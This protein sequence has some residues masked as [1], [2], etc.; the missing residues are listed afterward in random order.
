MPHTPVDTPVTIRVT[1]LVAD[2]CPCCAPK[3]LAIVEINPANEFNRPGLYHRLVIQCC[4]GV[5][6]YIQEDLTKEP[7]V[8]VHPFIPEITH[9]YRADPGAY[10]SD[11]EPE[12]FH[13]PSISSRN[14][15]L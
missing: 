12:V 9:P 2:N 14:A 10:K 1:L 7:N 5:A 4:T 3:T 6:R 15:L 11:N 13:E 8:I